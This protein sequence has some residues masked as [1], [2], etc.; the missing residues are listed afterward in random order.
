[1]VGSRDD[2]RAR[3]STGS[4]E[5]LDRLR[6]EHRIRAPGRGHPLQGWRQAAE[7]AA[8][9]FLAL[10]CVGVFLLLALRLQF[11][12]LGEGFNPLAVVAAGGLLGLV[13]LGAPL[14]LGE[15]EVVVI[16]MGALCLLGVALVWSSSTRV[17]AARKAG[18]QRFGPLT[19]GALTGV[20]FGLLCLLA[21]LA[22]RFRGG[23]DPVSVGA[24]QALL[25]GT[26]WGSLFGLLGALRSEVS[27]AVQLAAWGRAF[28]T[29]SRL[30]YEGL[31]SASVMLLSGAVLSC[32]A[33]LLW[34][35]VALVRN[36]VPI[37][38]SW[39]SA[40]AALIY[41]IAFL[42]NVVLICLALSLGAPVEVG[43]RI[44][45]AG[46]DFGRITEYSLL[47]WGGADT[48]GAA[49]VFL[50]VPLMA[51]LLGGGAAYRQ[52]ADKTAA[53]EV[54]GVAALCFGALVLILVALAE[55]RLGAGLFGRRGVA[56]VA[57]DPLSAGVLACGW[58]AAIGWAGWKLQQWRSR[59]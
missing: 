24:L 3:P 40:T 28:E 5:V 22:F 23:S 47:D 36:S 46:N 14:H 50:L 16:P 12:Q 26:L 42:P 30:A 19:H 10:L 39:R 38:L 4:T 25:W 32:A 45:V 8:L 7:S 11:E 58:G 56:R 27:A 37:D 34:A 29:R 20:I 43:G 57:A 21:A 2:E 1:M 31:C 59:P 18:G 9:A 13:S 55:A 33:L 17:A 15:V 54:V 35:I 51:C 53:L 41:L 49:F 44:S 6:R 52:A 48:P